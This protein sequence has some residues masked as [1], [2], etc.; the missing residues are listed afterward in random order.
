MYYFGAGAPGL[1]TRDDDQSDGGAAVLVEEALRFGEGEGG[2]GG[3]GGERGQAHEEEEGEGD[4]GLSD[5][6]E[7]MKGVRNES[8]RLRESVVAG[9][10]GVGVRWWNDRFQ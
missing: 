9:P 1:P 4:R 10:L 5:M 6:E 8:Q 3:G 7:D 2:R